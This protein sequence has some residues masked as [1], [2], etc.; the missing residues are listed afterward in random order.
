MQIS[1]DGSQIL[2]QEKNVSA[3]AEIAQH[4]TVSGKTEQIIDWPGEYEVS[5]VSVFAV[6]GDKG[7][8]AFKVGM[9]GIRI[10]FPATEAIVYDEEEMEIIGEPEVIYVTAD[11]G[12]RTVKEWKKFLETIDPRIIIFGEN[13]ETT[14]ALLKELGVAESE[15]LE[16]IEITPRNLPADKTRYISLL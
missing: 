12:E 5:G 6:G 14:Q 1:K 3:R 4:V 10:F 15:K 7:Q 16:E 9:E 13:G 2:L 11:S 8:V